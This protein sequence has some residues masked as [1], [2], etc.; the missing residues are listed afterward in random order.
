MPT[1]LPPH[2]RSV[3]VI[4]SAK[5]RQ[6]G[7]VSENGASEKL[8]AALNAHAVTSENPLRKR[9]SFRKPTQT[10][11]TPVSAH[12]SLRRHKK[13]S[14]DEFFPD[15]IVMSNHG[16]ARLSGLFLE[17]GTSAE[18][19]IIWLRACSSVDRAAAF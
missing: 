2:E 13:P 10:R 18:L 9:K 4:R 6:H 7:G 14:I 8:W 12:A 19:V 15:D 11:A 16:K 1:V 5:R 3:E 17:E